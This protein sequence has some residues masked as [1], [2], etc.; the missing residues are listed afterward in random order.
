MFQAPFR[1]YFK[2]PVKLNYLK[3]RYD[4]NYIFRSQIKKFDIIEYFKKLSQTPNFY[5]V[6]DKLREKLYYLYDI[7]ESEG[8][9]YIVT[10]GS[11]KSKIFVPFELMGDG[12]QSLLIT[13]ILFELSPK[14]IV[15]L[16]EPENCLH[17]GYMD[18]LVDAI[19]K[20]SENHQFF[21]STH[22]LDLIKILVEKAEKTNKLDKILLLRLN[23]RDNKINREILLKTEILEELNEIKVDLRGF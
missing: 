13:T 6:L 9:I 19:L 10:L 17:P 18:I 16:E 3:K 2:D 20:K 15:I 5:N 1:N 7:R 14:G 23:R 22:S 8:N 21:F 11:D 4:F 12:F